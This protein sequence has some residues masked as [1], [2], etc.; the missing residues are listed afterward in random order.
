MISAKIFLVIWLVASGNGNNI[1][2]YKSAQDCQTAHQ[3][4]LKNNNKVNSMCMSRQEL[5]LD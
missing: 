4:L 2:E 3:R 1:L 5:M